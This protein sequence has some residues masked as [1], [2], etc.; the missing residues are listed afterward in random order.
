V[1][2]D[3]RLMLPQN[4]TELKACRIDL[5]SESMKKKIATDF[6]EIERITRM[7]GVK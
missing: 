7:Q 2:Q 1:D 5:Q 6:V 3:D 4:T